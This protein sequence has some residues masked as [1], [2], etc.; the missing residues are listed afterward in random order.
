MSAFPRTPKWFWPSLLLVVLV[1]QGYGIF[2]FKSQRDE[3]LDQKQ[4]LEK[5]Q[6]VLEKKYAEEKARAGDL[7]RLK[8][9]WEAQTRSLQSDLEK[10]RQEHD[11]LLARTGGGSG[12]GPDLQKKVQSLE[13]QV[14]SLAQNLERS[15]QGKKDLERKAAETVQGLQS[16]IAQLED[17][18]RTLRADLQREAEFRER[19]RTDNAKLASLADELMQRFREKGVVDS[20]LQKEP[21]TQ[22]K[23]VEL[24]EMLQKYKEAKSDHLLPPDGSE[25]R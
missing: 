22:I 1:L 17:E 12:F 11:A 4:G 18:N 16:R 23:R 24:E 21:L 2:R 15:E 13:A 7:L 19:C 9:S 20:L 25:E 14:A 5:K 10:L 3:L 8:A 6:A